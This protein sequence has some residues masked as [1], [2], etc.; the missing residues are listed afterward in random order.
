MAFLMIVTMMPVNLLAEDG[1]ETS[2]PNMPTGARNAEGDIP[3]KNIANDAPNAVHAFVG[4]QTGGDANL[5][6]D[7][8]TGQEFHPIEGVKAYFQWFE[9]GGYVS[10]VYSAVSDANGRLNIDCKPYVA[11]DGKIIKFDADPTV[12]G[13]H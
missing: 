3:S 11:S 6:L 10:P 2:P 12:S 7:K 1:L 4:V 9:D 8:A 13:G 5:R